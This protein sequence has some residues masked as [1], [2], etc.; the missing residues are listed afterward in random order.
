MSNWYITNDNQTISINIYF[1]NWFG[2]KPFQWNNK[3]FNGGDMYTC[4]RFGKL[5]IH[6]RRWK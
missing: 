4:Y 2:G 5:L 3:R 6:V 1:I